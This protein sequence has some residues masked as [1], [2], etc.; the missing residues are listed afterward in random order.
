[1]LLEQ[2]SL[3]FLIYLGPFVDEIS[4]GN[5]IIGGH[6]AQPGAWPW[7]VSLQVYHFGVGYYHVC[8]GSLITNNSVLTAAH[9]IK[10]WTD[11]AVWR[12]VIGLHHLFH[13]QYY[14]VKSQI[15]AILK[16]SDFKKESY[17]NDVAMFILTDYVSFNKY[18]QPICLIDTPHLI[19][20]KTTCYISG[21]G[22]K[23]ERGRGTYILQEA[24]VNIIP[25]FTCNRFDW[26]AG[27]IGWNM[28]C[29]GSETGDVDS[30]QG[31]SGGPLTCRFPNDTKYYLIGI[32]SFGIGCGRP[33]LPGV[34]VRMSFYRSW[35]ESHLALFSKATIIYIHC[36][37][38]FLIVNCFMNILFLPIN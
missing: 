7:Q 28:I 4:A 16:H 25:L 33:K 22:S 5:R 8:G 15:R 21:W 2:L 35:I 38:I 34:Y 13:H 11:P 9:C 30:C 29:A 1:M 6:D 31:D 10:K 23:E 36:I 17:E 27:A 14:T 37:F 3:L 20:D 26:Y 19:T 18:I 32:T 12:V 24:Q